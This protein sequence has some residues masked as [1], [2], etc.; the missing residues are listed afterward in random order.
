[1]ILDLRTREERWLKY[2]VEHDDQQTEWLGTNR[3]VLPG[4]AFT[5]DGKELVLSYGGK[6]H[7]LDLATRPDRLIPFSA[8]S[9]RGMGP[10]LDFPARV[11][12]GP[13]KWR[14]LQG[15]AQSPEGK[16][17]AFSAA[18]HLYVMDTVGGVP[19]R[20][21]KSKDRE[22]QPIWSPDGRWVAYVTWS[23]AG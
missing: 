4:Y 14:I 15:V 1:K 17:L 23:G 12:E 10:L 18:T 8:K 19:H 2:P 13:V 7:R 6:I 5:P 22:Y 3:D 16:R 11:D 9:S 20:L 21:T